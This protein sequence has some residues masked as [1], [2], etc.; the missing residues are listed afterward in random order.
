MQ[1]RPRGQRIRGRQLPVR[2]QTDPRTASGQDVLQQCRADP[3]ASRTRI[4][5][6][7]RDRFFPGGQE[8]VAHDLPILLG[9]R[10]PLLV[11]ASGQQM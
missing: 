5:E 10:V 1:A 4:H 7:L 9:Q 2:P 3:T 8:R 11:P 6:E